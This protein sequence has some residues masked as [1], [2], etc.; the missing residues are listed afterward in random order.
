VWF[1]RTQST[2]GSG[3]NDAG[4]F[5]AA[6]R[7][8]HAVFATFYSPSEANKVRTSRT[9]LEVALNNPD[10]EARVAIA[11][12]L[13]DD[14]ADPTIG[15]PLHILGYVT[16]HDFRNEPELLTRLLDMG[17]DVNRVEVD[18]GTPLE[19]LA[20]MFKFDDDE[21]RPLYEVYLSHDDLDL[22]APGRSGRPVYR[23]LLTWAELRP[24]LVARA[25]EHLRARG[26]DPG[27]L[28][29]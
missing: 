8:S 4:L 27:L 9:L 12:Q 14:G 17:A 22:T 23:T 6:A 15:V 29:D 11:N 16:D 25:E 26:V 28:T 3:S 24:D 20:S 18:F 7:G 2:T 19:C 21:I 5:D 13:L 10:P 1:K